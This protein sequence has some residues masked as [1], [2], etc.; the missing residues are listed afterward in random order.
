MLRR[1]GRK[2]HWFYDQW[3]QEHSENLHLKQPDISE[4]YTRASQGLERI[5]P[6]T[7]DS[8]YNELE[9]ALKKAILLYL[10]HYQYQDI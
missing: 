4:T 6:Q 8:E 9:L 2:L 7:P 5:T 1:T 10:M 3:N